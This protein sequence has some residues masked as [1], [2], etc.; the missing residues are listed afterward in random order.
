R[1]RMRR[2]VPA[3][4][5]AFLGLALVV[6]PALAASMTVVDDFEA[7]EGWTATA[8][9]GAQVWI[10]QEPGRN[11]QALRI[12][13]DLGN[14][15]GFVIVRKQFNF[16]VPKN[17]AF[18]FG[19]LGEGLRNNFEFKLVDSTGRNVW[20]WRQRDFIWPTTWETMA[21]RRSRLDLAWG[22]GP[23]VRLQKVAAIALP[24]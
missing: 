21:V 19:L 24:I 16:S 7:I 17:F 22:T 18:T 5:A 3:I 10:A 9:E 20:W 11:G 8:S 15:S 13:Y 1:S 14:G 23:D 4:A 6:P 12:D 2:A